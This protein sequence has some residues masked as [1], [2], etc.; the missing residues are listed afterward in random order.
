MNGF[1]IDECLSPALIGVAKSRGHAAVHLVHL[2]RA[3]ASDLQV[4]LLALAQQ[5]ILVTNNRG[6]F[7]RR[8]AKLGTDHPGVVV[9][10][11]APRAQQIA[12]F[13]EALTAFES[14]GD[15]TGLLIDVVQTADVRI[16]PWPLRSISKSSTEA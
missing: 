15:L 13:E 16:G 11:N 8:Y 7:L 5:H 12:L 14:I 10:P 1:L 6:D 4:M 3:G 2:G 9:R